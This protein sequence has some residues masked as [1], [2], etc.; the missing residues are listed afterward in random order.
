MCSSDLATPSEKPSGAS[1]LTLRQKEV[2]QLLTEGRTAKDIANVLKISPR[3]VEFHKG[4]IM[5]HLKLET[6]TDLIKYALAHGLAIP[7]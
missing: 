1:G 6:T 7:T 5:E 4:Q 3:T 2:L